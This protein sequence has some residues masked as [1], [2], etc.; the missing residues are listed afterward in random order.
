MDAAAMVQNPNAIQQAGVDWL[1]PKP[2]HPYY[3]VAPRYVRTSAGIKV[4]HLLCHAL[5]RAGERAYLITHLYYLPQYATHPE[6]ITPI[7]TRATVEHDFAAGLA[8]IVVYPETIRGNL[9]R[10]PFLSADAV[11]A[12]IR[13]AHLQAARRLSNAALLPGLV[14]FMHELRDVKRYILK[15]ATIQPDVGAMDRLVFFM[16]R[17]ARRNP[18]LYSVG[19][20]LRAA[21]AFGLG[22]QTQESISSVSEVRGPRP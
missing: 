9:F 15:K 22:A 4:L 7:L 17:K 13:S 8:P 5:N 19:R 18:W 14:P 1:L 10:T 6:L 12:R 21:K 20:K 2:R 3:I 16:A 11:R